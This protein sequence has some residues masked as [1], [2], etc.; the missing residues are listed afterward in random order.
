MDFANIFQ[1]SL[2][3]EHFRKSVSAIYSQ[4]RILLQQIIS[5]TCFLM[6]FT[7]FRTNDDYGNI[8]LKNLFSSQIEVIIPDKK[9]RDLFASQKCLQNMIPNTYDICFKTVDLGP[10]WIFRK[11]N[12]NLMHLM[13][14][15]PY[16]KTGNKHDYQ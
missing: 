13:K 8:R 16:R 11:P 10:T 6:F 1:D 15:G 9:I 4:F 5:Q 3:T 7:F 14:T 12:P 2:I